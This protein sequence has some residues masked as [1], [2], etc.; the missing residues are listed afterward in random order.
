[1]N[2]TVQAGKVVARSVS[3]LFS[4]V[5]VRDHDFDKQ[6]LNDFISMAK[7]CQDVEP[8]AQIFKLTIF[9]S[10]KDL[11]TT[12]HSPRS[13]DL[14]GFGEW[15]ERYQ[16]YE[17]L[18]MASILIIGN[19]VVARKLNSNGRVDKKPDPPTWNFDLLD[20]SVEESTTGEQGAT[21]PQNGHVSVFVRSP[22]DLTPQ[23]GESISQKL[24]PESVPNVRVLIRN[25]AWFVNAPFF[26]V[27]YRF[28]PKEAVP[29][30]VPPG[31]TIKCDYKSDHQ[32]NCRLN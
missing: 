21:G 1:M 31:R 29:N 17:P 12:L 20:I 14:V 26:P 8:R 27:A 19:A 9:N 16:A 10:A 30:E 5:V 4:A 6:S 18:P 32:F 24:F 3:L 22:R 2:T 15:R 23:L 11:A 7:A 28:D 13:P 25:D